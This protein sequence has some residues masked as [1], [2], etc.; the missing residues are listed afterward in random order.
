M[1]I[2]RRTV[3]TG[4]I[5]APAIIA[6]RP[7]RAAAARVLKIGHPYPGGTVGEGDFR[8][9]LVRLFAQQVE[10]KTDG[11]LAFEIHPG[12]APGPGWISN[13]NAPFAALRQGTL[14]LGLYPLADAG[15]EVPEFDI[16]LMPCLVASYQQGLAW[17]KAPIGTEVTK[18][19]ED[20]GVKILTWI[21][22]AGAIAARDD[23]VVAPADAKGLKIRGGGRAMDLMLKG[24][25]G[26]AAP[27]PASGIHGALKSGALDAAV[28]SS[29]SL[30]SFGLTDVSKSLTSGRGRSFWYGLAPL[31]MSKAAF[32]ALPADQKTAITEVGIEM[33]PFAR[34]Q[35]KLDDEQAAALYRQANH[36]VAEID[37][38][39]IEQWRGIAEATA[40]RD[41]AARG[42]DCAR[43][44]KL[45]ASVA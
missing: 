11:A 22:Q 41:F 5:A 33:E 27:V 13:A 34:T 12:A 14:D 1:R 24:A 42:E 30:I 32:D 19:L 9:R 44:L 15:G 43:M 31:M 45:A 21:W 2:A 29:T 35:A 38:A 37:P 26:V 25:G 18:L 36:P 16:G 7:G 20:R 8:D 23:A 40:W 17:K 39:T 6:A 4:L 3:L 10:K 28:T